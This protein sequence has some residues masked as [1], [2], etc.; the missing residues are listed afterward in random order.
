MRAVLRDSR[1]HATLW[2]GVNL[3]IN[4]VKGESDPLLDIYSPALAAAGYVL[5]IESFNGTVWVGSSKRLWSEEAEFVV[6]A[7]DDTVA[8]ERMIVGL[9]CHLSSSVGTL[10]EEFEKAGR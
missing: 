6:G 2:V 3:G 7:P 10:L 1:R 9:K 4:N 8:T 5:D